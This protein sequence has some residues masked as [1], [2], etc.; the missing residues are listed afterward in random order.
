M[1]KMIVTFSGFCLH[2]DS[3]VG[4]RIL[5]KNLLPPPSGLKIFLSVGVN[6]SEK[7][8]FTILWAQ[9]EVSMFVLNFGL[10]Q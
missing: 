5:E 9:D 2:V 1:V 4:A 7:H 8:T 10:C 6:V 3:S